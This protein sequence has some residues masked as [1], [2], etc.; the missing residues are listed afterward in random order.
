MG[1]SSPLTQSRLIPGAPSLPSLGGTSGATSALNSGSS[2]FGRETPPAPVTPATQYLSPAAQPMVPGMPSLNLGTGQGEASPLPRGR[3]MSALA[4]PR[5]TRFIRLAIAAIFLFGF[6]GI[7]GYLFKDALKEAF[8]GLGDEAAEIPSAPQIPNASDLSPPSSISHDAPD[9]RQPRL[10]DSPDTSELNRVSSGDSTPPVVA[11]GTSLGQSPTDTPPRAIPASQEEI[12]TASQGEPTGAMPTESSPPS[13]ANEL[14]PVKISNDREKLL[15]IPTPSGS[16][17]QSTPT[18]S[19]D[20][21]NSSSSAAADDIPPKAQPALAALQSFL[22]SPTVADR[23]RYTL[24][25]DVMKPLM[26]RYYLKMSDGP[27]VVDHIGFSNYEDRPELGAGAH[28]IFRV[29]SKTWEYPVPVMLEK[30][31]DGW[32]VDWLAFVELKDR[33]L[34]EFFKGY[35]EGRFMFH[36]GIYRQHYFEDAVPNRDQKDAFSVGLERPNPFRAPVFLAKDSSLSKTLATRLPW[37]THVW[38]IVEL[39]WKKL[40]SQQWVELVS[41]PQ[42]HWY[43]VPTGPRPIS[44]PEQ[45]HSPAPAVPKAEPANE[46]FPPGIRRSPATGGR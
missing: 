24:A 45:P 2:L 38:A 21:A 36:V 25:A 43:S 20:I 39:E 22:S 26:D 35:T 33:K 11:Q 30:Q 18:S 3:N 46:A 23:S 8:A 28:C 12:R 32:K 42:M 4:A 29:E 40:G 9:G 7:A 19:S 16:G 17:D 5:G 10:P 37:E 15:E 34:E 44:T 27:I 13:I 14:Q 41:M 6:I 1:G 31:A